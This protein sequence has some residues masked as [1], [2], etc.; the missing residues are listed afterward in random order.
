MLPKYS[1]TIIGLSKINDDKT[2]T[3]PSIKRQRNTEQR[4]RW[5]SHTKRIAYVVM[6]KSGA[7]CCHFSKMSKEEALENTNK[8]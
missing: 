1:I 7:I 4:I 6:H 3:N 8:S 5:T 2:L